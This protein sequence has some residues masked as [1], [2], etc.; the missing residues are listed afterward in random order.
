M[1]T[2]EIIVPCFNEA[3]RLNAAAF[4][5]YV[6]E[7]PSVRFLFV[8]DG[9]T[10]RTSEVLRRLCATA[11][12]ELRQLDL[13]HNVG[14]AEAVRRGMIEAARRRPDF[15]GYWDADLATPLDA[16][17]RFA[18]LLE[19]RRELELVMGARVGLLGRAIRRK[20]SRHYLGRVFAT[21]V[22][23]LL[24]LPVYDTQCG[25]KL[26]RLSPGAIALFEEPFVSRWIFDVE[27]LA[28]LIC[29]RRATDLPVVERIVYEYPLEAW[30][31][32]D[33]SKLK[34][35]DFL[36]A[37]VELVRIYRRYLRGND[38]ITPPI[39]DGGEDSSAETERE[40]VLSR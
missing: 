4:R 19:W 11:P 12:D 7:E 21:V 22:S 16:I 10:D 33:G 36:R 34:R 32:V 30:C 39:A 25:A 35:S 9:S 18:D 28:R 40:G 6:E 31:D 23:W 26:F 37:A 5:R 20:P 15:I 24:G 38:V 29:A 27:I 3:H 14:K 17:R 2:T 8:N 1:P 13:D